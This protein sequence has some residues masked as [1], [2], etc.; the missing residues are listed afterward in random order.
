MPD[1][2]LETPEGL[3][4]RHELAGAGSRSAAGLIDLTLLGLL[5]LFAV[6]F[7]LSLGGAE[8]HGQSPGVADRCG[9]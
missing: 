7:L 4:L 8:A 6:L 9:L 2:V 5:M 3:T 1:L